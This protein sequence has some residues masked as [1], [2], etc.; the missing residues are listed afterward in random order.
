MFTFET[1]HLL[2]F[3]SFIKRYTVKVTVWIMH[4]YTYCVI[5]GPLK[6]NNNLRVTFQY[7]RNYKMIPAPNIT[8]ARL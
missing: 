7:K 8:T 4:F 3:N 5:V 2:G 6:N 1:T